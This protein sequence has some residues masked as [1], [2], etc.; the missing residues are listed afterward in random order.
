MP[1]IF[2]R[3]F[4]ATET[5][6]PSRRRAQNPGVLPSLRWDWRDVGHVF[7]KQGPLLTCAYVVLNWNL[8]FNL[9]EESLFRLRDERNPWLYI[10]T[11][12]LREISKDHIV[13]QNVIK[14]LREGTIRGRQ[15]W[16]AFNAG[17]SF[18]AID[19]NADAD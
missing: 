3:R 8:E 19:L 5:G 9:D 18:L 4:S 15:I 10:N 13:N 14:G 17:C 11:G 1:G 16:D 7:E 12:N 2:P 6:L